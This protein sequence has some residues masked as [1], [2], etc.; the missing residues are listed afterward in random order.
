MANM[1]DRD[2]G[3]VIDRE[4]LKVGEAKL[5][6]IF[7]TLEKLDE[8]IELLSY[9]DTDEAK[10]LL[11]LLV[12]YKSTLQYII[13]NNDKLG[14][15]ADDLAKG[16]FNGKRKLDIDLSLNKVGIAEAKTTA[17]ALAIWQNEQNTVYYDK[18]VATFD[19]GAIIEVIFVNDGDL[20]INISTS[21]EL[22]VQ[23]NENSA[24]T[25][26]LI[27]TKMTTDAA[28]KVGNILRILDY[29]DTLS[30]LESIKL[31]AVSGDFVKLEP[32][33]TWFDTTSV[34]ALLFDAIPE[35]LSV[36]E[37]IDTAKQ[38]IDD[39]R[40]S[41]NPTFAE[42]DLT[43]QFYYQNGYVIPNGVSVFDLGDVVIE[44]KKTLLFYGGI[45]IP[46]SEYTIDDN[47]H[48]LTTSQPYNSGNN[49]DLRLYLITDI[50]FFSVNAANASVRKGIIQEVGRLT[51]YSSNNPDHTG[52]AYTVSAF[53]SQTAFET[54]VKFGNGVT[55]YYLKEY[56]V[57]IEI[58]K[59]Q[60][61]QPEDYTHYFWLNDFL[62]MS[63]KNETV[64]SCNVSWVRVPYGADG[65]SIP[66]QV[67]EVIA[68]PL[69][70]S[71][72]EC[73]V[74]PMYGTPAPN[75]DHIP[76]NFDFTIKSQSEWKDFF[77]TRIYLTVLTT[78]A[79]Q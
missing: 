60:S 28:G 14:L 34:L 78:R 16:T 22:R 69:G 65:N 56:Y 58:P 27:N 25:N 49:K 17:E 40:D 44:D 7:S 42:I 39:F 63:Y 77:G 62:R 61:H 11:G 24:F 53:F 26:K 2:K 33:Y 23:L 57:C 5:R 32:K 43:P 48:T 71:P 37:Q 21:A 12:K 45:L 38:A 31:H 10:S 8:L 47:T 64:I 55:P 35:V 52:T 46:R 67:P 6:E 4:A 75:P 74:Y 70:L 20:P 9:Y 3:N 51:S 73:V 72:L 41:F 19:D 1:F 79:A 76:N 15:I 18:A 54:L 36:T 68:P 59:T 29:A 13:D 30:N 50:T 66:S